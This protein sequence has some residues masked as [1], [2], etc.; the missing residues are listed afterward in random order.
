ML[1]LVSHRCYTSVGDREM[2]NSQEAESTS[3]STTEST[4]PWSDF[5]TSETSQLQVWAS[6]L[7]R[8][9]AGSIREDLYFSR[10]A[11]ERLGKKQ[12]RITS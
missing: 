7:N 9:G 5:R 10:I 11:D 6:A 2:L 8:T 12:K 4:R 3:R 1:V